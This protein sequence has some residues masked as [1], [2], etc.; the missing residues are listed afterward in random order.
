M[1]HSELTPRMAEILELLV[2]AYEEGAT[3]PTRAVSEADGAT[4][5]SVAAVQR[6]LHRRGYLKRRVGGYDLTALARSWWAS[7]TAR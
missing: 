6:H 4:V 5:S 3:D 7:Q 1:P 2:Y